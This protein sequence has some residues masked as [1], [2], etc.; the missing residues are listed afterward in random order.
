MPAK[1]ILAIVLLFLGY[2]SAEILFSAY[3]P[4]TL[5]PQ[6][7]AEVAERSVGLRTI[8]VPSF[9]VKCDGQSS[10]CD[11]LFAISIETK[12]LLLLKYLAEP[13]QCAPIRVH[14]FVDGDL[15]A[16]TEYL[17]SAR[18]A[19]G[20]SGGEAG[21]SSTWLPAYASVIDIL[22]SGTHSVELQAEV[23]PG[24]CNPDGRLD[25]WGGSLWVVVSS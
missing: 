20:N 1:V 8:K 12:S 10:K 6:A 3:A 17:S 14:V 11:D 21:G 2:I 18:V 4:R 19:A 25:A 22:D 15:A 7:D 5:A 23:Q 24:S 16:T 9:T 13:E